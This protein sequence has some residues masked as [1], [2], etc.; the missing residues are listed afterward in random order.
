MNCK[1]C[2]TIL[3]TES[4]YCY[5]CG[6][7]VIRNRLTLKHLFQDFSENYFNYDNKFYQTFINLFKKPEDV[8]GGY[9]NG[10]RKKYVNVVSY[11]AL[12]ITI[13]GIYLLILNNFF[14]E[15]MDFS[16][17]AAPGQE[18]FQK[19]NLSFVQEYQ[20][21]F[22][23]LYVPLYALM[24]RVSFIGIKKF[25]YTELLVIFMYLQ[26]QIS[27]VSAIAGIILTL[28][29]ITQGVMSLI[30]IPLM[31]LY[32]AF[33]LKRLYNL[34]F[35]HIVL[36]T[37]LFLVVLGIVFIIISVVMAVIM[38]INGDLQSMIEA[39]KAASGK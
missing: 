6:G 18:E 4:G 20:S 3:S 23:M 19:K 1:N 12:A 24:A 10:T 14:P 7:K 39:K 8:I 38:F 35:Q 33:C 21:L 11:F 29:G 37:L 34:N 17:M 28:F 13:S 15:M 16:V 22:M 27:I 25:N 32:S 36:R 30:A 2:N 9:I 26:A 31:I 5:C